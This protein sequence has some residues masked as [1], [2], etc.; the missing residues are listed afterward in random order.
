MQLASGRSGG[1]LALLR[2][3]CA[4]RA[5]LGHRMLSIAAPTDGELWAWGQND[6]GNMKLPVRLA[7]HDSLQGVVQVSV[8]L[9]HAGAVTADGKLYTWGRG[10]ARA[11][12]P[13]SL[14]TAPRTNQVPERAQGGRLG[15]N[16]DAWNRSRGGIFK[17]HCPDPH[18]V[19]LHAPLVEQ[20]VEVR[21]AARG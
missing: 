19:D 21:P 16:V 15:N 17:L 1:A 13:V 14:L 8:G 18:P 12:H 6:E 11:S 5:P 2:H 9:F 7:L 3:C 4:C 20:G 10:E